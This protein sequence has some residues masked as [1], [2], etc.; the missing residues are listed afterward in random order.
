MANINSFSQLSSTNFLAGSYSS[1]IS[2]PRLMSVSFSSTTPTWDKSI[3][4]V[5]NIISSVTAMSAS[6][7]LLNSDGSKVYIFSPIGNP[8]YLLFLT[9]QVSDGNMVDNHFVSSIQC[10]KMNALKLNNGNLY[11]LAL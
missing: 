7:S 1:S 6:E 8:S 2:Q 5:G 9:L 10:T 3:T 11:G 4:S